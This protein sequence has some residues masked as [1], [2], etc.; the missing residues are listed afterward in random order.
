MHGHL[1]DNA[2]HTRNSKRCNPI[3]GRGVVLERENTKMVLLPSVWRRSTQFGQPE[4][5]GANVGNEKLHKG[6]A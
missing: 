2:S 4:R 6:G 1:T 3:H 5:F